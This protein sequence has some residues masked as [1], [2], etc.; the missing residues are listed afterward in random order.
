MYPNDGYHHLT[1]PPGILNIGDR[2]QFHCGGSLSFRIHRHEGRRKK[3][4]HKKNKSAEDTGC[5]K[6]KQFGSDIQLPSGEWSSN[7]T[8][9]CC[10]AR[11]TSNATFRRKTPKQLPN[12]IFFVV[13]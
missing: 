12:L 4:K 11:L 2:L 3:A 8:I 5:D 7:P 1:N 10:S 6:G 9:S 13:E